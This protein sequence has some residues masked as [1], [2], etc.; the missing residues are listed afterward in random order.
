MNPKPVP[1]PKK[2]FPT[3]L[4]TQLAE[5]DIETRFALLRCGVLVALLLGL[6]GVTHIGSH[7][8][9][10]LT[11]LQVTAG[12][13]LLG[14]IG[15]LVE[16]ARHTKRAPYQTALCVLLDV[17]GAGCLAYFLDDWAIPLYFVALCLVVAYGLRYGSG[18]MMVA[19]A[20]FA[21]GFGASVW[22]E[23]Y[24]M[25]H[26]T[27]GFLLLAGMAFTALFVHANHR[28]F[29][30]SRSR[31]QGEIDAHADFIALLG[32][33]L[34]MSLGRLMGDARENPGKSGSPRLTRDWKSV[35]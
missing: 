11:W 28:R 16:F 14:A 34:R 22:L 12:L 33:E 1:T 6:T 19:L 30:R 7:P 24:W 4:A 8:L 9:S 21:A 5:R 2:Q 32:D 35:V 15:M 23:A 13:L 27:T 3:S 25:G 20:T 18:I 26:R 31:L 17:G 29:V 10:W